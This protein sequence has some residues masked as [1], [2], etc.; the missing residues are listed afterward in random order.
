MKKKRNRMLE[1][2]V[3]VV[4][5]PALAPFRMFACM[6]YSFLHYHTP[7]TPQ[8]NLPN[9]LL[10]WTSNQIKD[11]CIPRKNSDEKKYTNVRSGEKREQKPVRM[12]EAKEF[13]KDKR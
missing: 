12:V 11:G 5:V 2:V 3:V 1:A 4:R 13:V 6:P 8:L 9:L 7:N 10:A